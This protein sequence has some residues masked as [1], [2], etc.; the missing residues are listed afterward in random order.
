MR[1]S[2]HFGTA[3]RLPGDFSSNPPLLVL[4]KR[5]PDETRFDELREDQLRVRFG[6]VGHRVDDEFGAERR[7][8][9]VVDAREVLDPT[10]AREGVHALRVARLADLQRRVHEDLEETFVAEHR[11]ALVARRAVRADGRAD[12]AAAVPRYLAGHEPDAADVRV[13]ILP[14]E[15]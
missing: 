10:L 3:T 7:L 9:R 1:G 8:V 14:A 12:D 6:R 5:L 15:A 2:L 11:A 4:L 13:A